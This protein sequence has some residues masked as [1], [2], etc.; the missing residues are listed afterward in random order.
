[1]ARKEYSHA[2]VGGESKY[3][4]DEAARQDISQLQTDVAGK[5]GKSSLETITLVRGG[6]TDGIYNLEERYPVDQCNIFVEPNGD[7]ITDEQLEAWQKA[8][9]VGS[10]TKNQIVAKGDVPTIDIPVTVRK[11]V[12]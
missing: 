1:M 12:L 7:E 3:Y 8:S 2:V 10:P 6:W 11:V 4:M 9:I 5:E